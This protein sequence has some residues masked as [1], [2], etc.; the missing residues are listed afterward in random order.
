[1]TLF[2]LPARATV[3]FPFEFYTLRRKDPFMS[4]WIPK[5]GE[6]IRVAAQ[7]PNGPTLRIGREGTVASPPIWGCKAWIT[8]EAEGREPE[9]SHLLSFRFLEPALDPNRN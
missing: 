4:K 5:E 3:P 6:R 9:E 1:M 7:A 2:P 8:F